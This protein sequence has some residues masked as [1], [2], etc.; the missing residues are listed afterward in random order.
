MKTLIAF[1]SNF[2]N[3]RQVAAYI[4][5]QI[6]SS[7]SLMHVDDFK[8]K[9]LEGVGLL[10]VGCPINAWSPTPKIKTFLNKMAARKLN[11]INVAAF[12]TRV[13]SFISGNAAKKIAR[14]LANLGGQL[15]VPGEGF[16][17]K[18]KEGPLFEGEQKRIAEWAGTLLAM[19]A[20]TQQ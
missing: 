11:G 2:G 19:A 20:K 10:I 18:G 16:Y 1:D 3:T 17:V 6:G 7:A 4:A 14:S 13:R 5:G 9:D 12:D 15:L 8:Q